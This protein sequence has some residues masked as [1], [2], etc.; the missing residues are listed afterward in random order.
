MGSLLT[1]L[2]S[3]GQNIETAWHLNIS[4]TA[5]CNFITLKIVT[6]TKETFCE[7]INIQKI[8]MSFNVICCSD[9]FVSLNFAMIEYTGGKSAGLTWVCN[10]LY[11]EKQI[12]Q[13]SI[14]YRRIG[15]TQ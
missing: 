11:D 1:L 6:C 14:S 10:L 2:S 7:C 13:M 12:L 3:L 8:E 9:I 5:I 15:H 4:L